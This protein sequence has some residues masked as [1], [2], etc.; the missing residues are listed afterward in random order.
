MCVCVQE[1]SSGGR[2]EDRKREPQSI[3]RDRT[4]FQVYAEMLAI[5][6]KMKVLYIHMHTLLYNNTKAW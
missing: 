5:R 4:E 3:S 1:S 6:N 2:R